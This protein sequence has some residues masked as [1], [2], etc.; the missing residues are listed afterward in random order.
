MTVALYLTI[1]PSHSINF[2]KS[3]FRQCLEDELYAFSSTALPLGK[4]D[5]SLEDLNKISLNKIH[6]H[7]NGLNLADELKITLIRFNSCSG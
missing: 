7:L 4:I 5:L 1:H 3:E 2:P 6:S